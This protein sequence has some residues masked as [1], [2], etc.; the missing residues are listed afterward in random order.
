MEQIEQAFCRDRPSRNSL[1]ITWGKITFIGR[2]T[3]DVEEPALRVLCDPSVCLDDCS[4]AS[5]LDAWTGF[6][7]DDSDPHNCEDRRTLPQE[8]LLSGF[9]LR[10]M[11][12]KDSH[13]QTIGILEEMRQRWV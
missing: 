13:D 9:V 6:P 3:I 5:L 11:Y 10:E 2:G 1:L 4:S 12:L 8:R 7:G